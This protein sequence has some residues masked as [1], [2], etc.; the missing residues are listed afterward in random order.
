MEYIEAPALKT[1]M[2]I[3]NTTIAAGSHTVVE[4]HGADRRGGAVDGAR[5]T[6]HR[7]GYHSGQDSIRLR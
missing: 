6:R 1:E 3:R 5:V 4:N 2:G 7:P